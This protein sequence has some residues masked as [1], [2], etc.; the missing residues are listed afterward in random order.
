MMLI[1][2]V[3]TPATALTYGTLSSTSQMVCTI[4]RITV[5][6]AVLFPE[7]TS[8]LFGGSLVV[9]VGVL[10]VDA[11]DG[12][13]AMRLLFDCNTVISVRPCF[14]R[15]KNLK[16][17]LRVLGME[18]ASSLDATGTDCF[19]DGDASDWPPDGFRPKNRMVA[20]SGCALQCCILRSY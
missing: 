5:A 2:V 8:L 11:I 17:L 14:H 15:W 12:E 6:L 20:R 1:A 16:G 10:G 13:E 3:A 4:P 7:A 18:A 9:V 19:E